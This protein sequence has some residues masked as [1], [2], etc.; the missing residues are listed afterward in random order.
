[1][2]DKKMNTPKLDSYK[3]QFEPYFIGPRPFGHDERVF[4][5]MNNG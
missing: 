2:V 3:L 1:L 4:E 5:S